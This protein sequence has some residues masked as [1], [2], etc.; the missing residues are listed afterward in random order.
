MK[1][2]FEFDLDED[3]ADY[4][5]YNSAKEMYNTLFE[6]RQYLRGELKYNENLTEGQYEAIEKVS[7][8]FWEI[9][10]ENKLKIEI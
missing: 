7:D 9:V 6:F 10:N 1:A 2:I 5:I 8:K 3:L 4:E